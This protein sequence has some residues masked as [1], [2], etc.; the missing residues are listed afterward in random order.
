M[1]HM[2]SRARVHQMQ[3]QQRQRPSLRLASRMQAPSHLISATRTS[4]EDLHNMGI[5]EGD[6][7]HRLHH[8]RP[9]IDKV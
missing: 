7:K 9:K 4:W 3:L 8:V 6:L 1:L 5:Y 2:N